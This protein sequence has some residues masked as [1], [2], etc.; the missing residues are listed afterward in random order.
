MLDKIKK[1]GKSVISI[2]KINDIFAGQGIT[3]AIST[4]SND[5]GMKKTFEISKRDV[6][7]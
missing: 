5:D 4:V 1:A 6:T 3:E 7:E 2:G